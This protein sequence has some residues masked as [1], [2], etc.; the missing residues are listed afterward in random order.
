MVT[1]RN[2]Q[3]GRSLYSQVGTKVK[4]IT[5]VQK[6]ESKGGDGGDVTLNVTIW[7]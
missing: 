4:S 6:K 1:R 2:R 5:T 7:M 3:E